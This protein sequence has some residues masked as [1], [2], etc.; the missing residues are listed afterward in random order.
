MERGGKKP[1]VRPDE[2][3]TPHGAK[4]SGKPPFCSF[5]METEASE[6]VYA[7]ALE[8]MGEKRNKVI[9]SSDYGLPACKRLST[10][11][12]HHKHRWISLK[13]WQ[14]ATAI[15]ITGIILFCAWKMGWLRRSW[16]VALWG[17]LLL[18]KSSGRLLD[19]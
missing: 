12:Y 5:G 13:W 16:I 17:E 1:I 7:C 9:S 8:I 11:R 10:G 15:L 14:R 6:Q 18:T 2:D 19:K 3:S 4:A